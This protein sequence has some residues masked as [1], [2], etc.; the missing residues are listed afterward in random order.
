MCK[1]GNIYK[2]SPHLNNKTHAQVVVPAHVTMHQPITGVVSKEPDDREPAIGN[3]YCVLDGRIYEVALNLS[4]FV[5]GYDSI[6]A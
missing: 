1:K 3:H 5:H 6:F 4:P 2:P